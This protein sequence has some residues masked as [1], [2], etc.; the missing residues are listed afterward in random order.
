MWARFWCQRRRFLLGW[1]GLSALLW[2]HSLNT[3]GEGDLDPTSPIMIVSYIVAVLILFTPAFLALIFL[4][5]RWRAVLE[6]LLLAIVADAAL[7]VAFP[8]AEGME[9]LGFI[10][11]MTC[12]LITERLL[13]SA[14]L[15]G[16]IIGQTRPRRRIFK[17]KA[18]PQ[19]AWAALLPHPEYATRHWYPGTEYGPTQR[20]DGA[21]EAHYPVRWMKEPM[22]EWI[23][24]EAA[25]T[26]H[27][28]RARFEL[29]HPGDKIPHTGQ[30]E[31]TLTPLASGE[32]EVSYTESLGPAP[33]RRRL[34]W[35]MDDE[36]RDRTNSLRAHLDNRPDWSLLARQF[37][38]DARSKKQTAQMAD[39]FS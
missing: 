14:L 35:W 17:T 13:Y 33:F 22:T 20:E 39:V 5:P 21:Y 3:L 36:F 9:T 32:T 19:A 16:N 4:L 11:F 2:V 23:A 1:A 24:I 25:E 29:N 10:R 31:V 34:Q 12:I 18:S 7:G 38:K 30:L 27:A 6:I 15:T 8:L 26:E 28:F 37:P